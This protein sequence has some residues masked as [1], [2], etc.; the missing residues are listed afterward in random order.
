MNCEA[1]FGAAFTPENA[2]RL[3]LT[4]RPPNCTSNTTGLTN[5]RKNS[6]RISSHGQ[7]KTQRPKPLGFK[8]VARDF[9]RCHAARAFD[10]IDGNGTDSH[11]LHRVREIAL[12]VQGE[13][14][15]VDCGHVMDVSDHARTWF[16]T[17][18][19][20]RRDDDGPIGCERSQ[21]DHFETPFV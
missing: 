15:S 20:V 21:V 8:S 13:I 10:H 6:T 17:R 19:G 1:T 11:L 3:E 18:V 9:D 5:E 12:R 2:M 7:K 4:A 16:T 14:E